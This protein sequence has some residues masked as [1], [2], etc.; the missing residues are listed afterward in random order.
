MSN[1]SK[2]LASAEKSIDE[3][4]QAVVTTTEAY[5]ALAIYYLEM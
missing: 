1:L 4:H 3:A 5:N 2:A